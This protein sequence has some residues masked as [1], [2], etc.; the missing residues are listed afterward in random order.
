MLKQVKNLIICWISHIIGTI[1]EQIES[2]LEIHKHLAITF[3]HQLIC[4]LSNSQHY[5]F[6]HSFSFHDHCTREPSRRGNMEGP[7]LHY[8]FLQLSSL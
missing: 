6:S 4:L 8:L 7:C 5:N 1:S 3:N 2:C